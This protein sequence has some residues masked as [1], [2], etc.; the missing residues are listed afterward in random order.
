MSVNVR[1]P[2]GVVIPAYDAARWLAETIRS[3]Q[4]QTHPDW[5]C[6]VVDDGSN[7]DTAAVAAALAADDERI[8]IHRQANGGVS[9]ARNAGTTLL[10]AAIDLISYLDSDDLLLSDA[11]ADLSAALMARPDA[12]GSY[13]IAEYVDAGGSPTEPGEQPRRQ[14]DRRSVI[15]RR[16]SS[17]DHGAD[18]TFAELVVN[19]PIVP[20][21]VCL[22]RR[23]IVTAVGGVERAFEPNEDWELY[24]RM[25][26]RGPF[27][28]LDRQVAWYRRHDGNA[29]G[30]LRVLRAA[31]AEVRH[32]MWRDPA[33]TPQQRRVSVRA[34]RYLRLRD[35]VLLG[36]QARA[37]LG[38]GDRRGAATAALGAV[39]AGMQ[40]L[41]PGPPPAR[42]AFPELTTP[43]VGGDP[44]VVRR[45][46]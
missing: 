4:A 30:R 35:A 2:L 28:A 32:R 44:V 10:P 13:G 42:W 37:S 38:D 16:L 27:V 25:S 46:H 3:L 6:V 26:R 33:N 23:D 31:Q 24:A 39:V 12:V 29:S 41:L 17:V 18:V 15:G 45:R 5:I 34:W 22:L 1:P 21:S 7:D 20:S 40:L 8:T 14:R 36:R 11:F 43:A 19:G 9:A